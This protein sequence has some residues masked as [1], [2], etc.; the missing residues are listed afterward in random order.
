M[1]CICKQA[2][3]KTSEHTKLAV[4]ARMA[5]IG[6]KNPTETIRKA[7]CPECGLLYSYDI[8]KARNNSGDQDELQRT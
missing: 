4:P 6:G 3:I 1:K 5:K 7:W 2:E 8:V